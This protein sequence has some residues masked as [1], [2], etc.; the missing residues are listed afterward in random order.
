MT[1][2]GTMSAPLEQR[3]WLCD[4]DGVLIAEGKMVEGADRFLGRLRETATPFLVLTNN[5]LFSP[6]EISHSLAILGLDVEE[7]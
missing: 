2:N 7:H 6:R 4:M 3:S 5:S 1:N